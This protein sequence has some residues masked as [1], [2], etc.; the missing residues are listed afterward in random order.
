MVFPDKT[1]KEGEARHVTIVDA[2]GRYRLLKATLIILD[3]SVFL[4]AIVV[5]YLLRFDFNIPTNHVHNLI[6]QAP[7]LIVLQFVA[8][9]MTGGRNFIR[10]YTGMTQGKA[11]IYEDLGCM[12]AVALMRLLLVGSHQVWRA[13]PC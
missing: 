4:I 6:A 7:F 5:S 11:L 1:M 2:L 3:L 9:T 12:A 8:L 13:P 10:R